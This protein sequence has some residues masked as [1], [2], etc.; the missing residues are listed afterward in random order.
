MVIVNPAVPKIRNYLQ[1]ARNNH[2]PID[3]EINI[4]F[5]LCPAPIIGITGSNGKSTTTTLTGKIL[6]ETQRKTWIGGNIG[7]SLL[8][9]L[10]EMKLQISWCSNSPVFNWKNL[11]IQ[12]K[13]SHQY[14]N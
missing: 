2:V 6:E 13:S 8:G 4:F 7:K 5:Q 10:D 1:I 14:C 11:T 9:C 3:T 12:K